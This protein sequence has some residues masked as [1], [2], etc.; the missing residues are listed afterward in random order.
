MKNLRGI[1]YFSKSVSPEAELNWL[2][3]KFKYRLLGAS[4][5][6]NVGFEWR[7]LV[8]LPKVVDD[9]VLDSLLQA[10][11]YVCPLIILKEES[12]KDFDAAL[13]VSLKTRE[14]LGDRELKFNLR[15]ANYSITDLYLKSIELADKNALDERRR[16]A[17]DDLKRFWRVKSDSAGRTLIAYLD[18]L[19]IKGDIR[20][21]TQKSIIPCLV[22]DLRAPSAGSLQEERET[23]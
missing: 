6:L 1:L 13:V 22:L 18:P 4:E 2:K 15:L 12:L 17:E 19:L 14:K 5:T 3:G 16:I 7:G 21:P 10:S 23:L 9:P 11:M 8:V 20:E